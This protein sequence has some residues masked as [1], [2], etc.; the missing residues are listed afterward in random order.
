MPARSKIDQLPPEIK[1]EFD[2]LLIARNFSAYDEI[3]VWLNDR[4]RDAGME[5][6]ISRA[7]AHRYG[8]G[9]EA[10]L[11]AIKIATEQARAIAEAVGDDAGLMGDALTR[12]CQEK[13]FQVLSEMEDLD[14]KDVDFVQL[15]TAISKLNRTAVA[16]KKWQIEARQQ[17][18]QK[19]AETIEKTAKREG[20]SAETIK[21]IRRDVLMMAS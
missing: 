14:P 2:R 18:L 3:A 11:S 10:K 4:L 8:Q 12:L 9:F 21:K 13:S 15:T 6:T 19:A 16:Q 5:V 7:A 1:A 17:L 20:V